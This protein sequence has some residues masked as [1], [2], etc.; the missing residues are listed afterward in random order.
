MAEE[1]QQ[2]AISSAFPAPPPFYK[3]FTSEKLSQLQEHF[4]STGQA[5]LLAFDP[6]EPAKGSI[7][8]TEGIPTDLQSLLWCHTYR[9]SPNIL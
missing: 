6:K 3:S 1:G 8:K 4:E 7:P 5:P 2:S 9:Q